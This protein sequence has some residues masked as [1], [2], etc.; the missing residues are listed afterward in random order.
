MNKKDYKGYEL[1]K[2]IYDGEIK[3]YTTIEVHDLSTLD[4][5]KSKIEYSNKRLNWI[6]GEFDTT[7]LFDDNIYFRVLEDNTEE[8][9]EIGEF[10]DLIGMSDE[11][12]KALK[13]CDIIFMCLEDMMSEESA[14]NERKSY[15]IIRNLI[16][17]QQKEISLLKDQLE[18]VKSEYEE[19][20]EQQQ[21][22]IEEL[23]DKKRKLIELMN[24]Y[25]YYGDLDFAV[26]LYKLLE[27]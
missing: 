22:E 20:I 19:T 23:K 25:D 26:E 11:E 9:E 6:A 7:C 5:I 12:K 2:A 14:N 13:D 27:V 21:K 17:T 10:V 24:K 4:H 8:I 15:K 1:I 3:D 18:Y 16:E